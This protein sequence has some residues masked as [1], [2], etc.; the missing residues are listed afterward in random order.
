[1]EISLIWAMARNGVIGRGDRLPWRLPND[2]AFFVAT[3]M[4]KPV[5]MGRRTFETLKVPLPGRTNIVITRDIGYSQEGIL[6]AHDFNEAVEL[7]QKQCRID[8]CDETMVAGGAEVYRMGLDLATRLYVTHVEAV[9]EGDTVFP[10]LDWT[11]WRE[12]KREEFPAD[13]AH[14]YPFSICGYER[15]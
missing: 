6:V 11:A 4:G 8:G 7:A 15:V 10:E 14:N 13:E 2:M 1:M 9:V 5:I 12:V 3:T